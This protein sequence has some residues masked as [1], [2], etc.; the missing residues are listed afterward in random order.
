MARLEATALR[1]L[2]KDRAHRQPSAQ[3]FLEEL[4]AALGGPI[5]TATT[6]P[7]TGPATAAVA[8]PST[9]PARWPLAVVGA[10]VLAGIGAAVFFARPEGPEVPK[11]AGV[12]ASGAPTQTPT[13]PPTTPPTQPPTQTPTTPPTQP[14]TDAPTAPPTQPP[15][16]PPTHAPTAPA[17]RAPAVPTAPATRPARDERRPAKLFIRSA[18]PGVKVY[19]D[20]RPKGTTPLVNFEVPPGVHNVTGELDGRRES[21]DVEVAPGAVKNVKFKL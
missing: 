12:P 5:V 20:G 14:P 6:G 21:I 9:G 15:T 16:A 8:A 17:T 3:V 18:T 10:A 19:V 13:A 2:S 4:E 1:A 11:D 7:T